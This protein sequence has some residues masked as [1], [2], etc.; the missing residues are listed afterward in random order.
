MMILM[1]KQISLMNKEMILMI[2]EMRKILIEAREGHKIG[3]DL[4]MTKIHS[5]RETLM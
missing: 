4:T 2:K 5:L 1:I 3:I